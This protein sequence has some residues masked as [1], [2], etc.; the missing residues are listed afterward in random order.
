MVYI[1]MLHL[2]F[3]LWCVGDYCKCT[4]WLELI[5]SC[6]SSC[7]EYLNAPHAEFQIIKKTILGWLI[8]H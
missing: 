1:Y 2:H 7:Q 8:I 6:Q 4:V 5:I 3:E